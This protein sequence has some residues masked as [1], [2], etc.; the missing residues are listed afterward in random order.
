MT[1]YITDTATGERITLD[2]Y[3]D[4]L[5]A[6]LKE[7]PSFPQSTPKVEPPQDHG[8]DT[9]LRFSIQHSQYHKHY[10]WSYD[11]GDGD[12]WG[13]RLPRAYVLND[14][15]LLINRQL[16]SFLVGSGN[17]RYLDLWGKRGRSHLYEVARISD[18]VNHHLSYP[19]YTKHQEIMRRMGS[20]IWAEL[21]S[22]L[23]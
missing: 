2:E 3:R 17:A 23:A 22:Y 10:D 5:A 21:N 11:E 8:I 1:T 16:A 9:T 13:D 19:P 7:K 20:E 4:R 15:T 18:D 12:L 6:R 14:G